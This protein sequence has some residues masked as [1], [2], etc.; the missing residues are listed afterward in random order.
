MRIE[1][2]LGDTAP[3]PRGGT[4]PRRAIERGAAL[5]GVAKR[6]RL[7]CLF[8]TVCGDMRTACCSGVAGMIVLSGKRRLSQFLVPRVALL[9]FSWFLWCRSVSTHPSRGTRPP[10]SFSARA[11]GN[12][13]FAA[14]GHRHT[15]A[16]E[17]SGRDVS[18]LRLV[19]CAPIVALPVTSRSMNREISSTANVKLKLR[20]V[21]SVWGHVAHP[22][23]AG[24]Q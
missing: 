20:V 23:G 21:G 8:L 11:A 17:E 10:Y 6:S 2:E 22:E 7:L 24:G 15:V 4:R 3:A 9:L 13:A 5:P 16:F 12:G 14:A 1:E 18:W 19:L